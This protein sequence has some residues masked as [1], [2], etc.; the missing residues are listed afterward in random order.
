MVG[1]CWSGYPT[2]ACWRR[3]GSPAREVGTPPSVPADP[4]GR[5]YVAALPAARADHAVPGPQ[6]R[7]SEA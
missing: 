7:R 5:E 6:Y 3:P 2:A 1:A 4:V